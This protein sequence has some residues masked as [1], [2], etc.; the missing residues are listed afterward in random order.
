MSE[1]IFE[2]L[3]FFTSGWGHFYSIIITP[4]I[5]LLPQFDRFNPTDKLTWC[6]KGPGAQKGMSW[7]VYGNPNKKF[8]GYQWVE[9]TQQLYDVMNKPF[10]KVFPKESITMR[11]VEHWLCEFQKYVK[12]R[13]NYDKGVKCKYRKYQGA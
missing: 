2:S 5:K 13:L 1:F 11:E 6:N 7:L 8:T 9:Y 4:V 10:E 3:D 12:Y